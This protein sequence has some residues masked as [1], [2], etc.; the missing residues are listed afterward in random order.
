METQRV[1][2]VR[3]DAELQQAEAAVLGERSA[4]GA[5]RALGQ[6]L[7]AVADAVMRCEGDPECCADPLRNAALGRAARAAVDAG[8]EPAQLREVIA[9]AAAG[10][11]PFPL[12]PPA[13]KPPLII[14]AQT[15]AA[16]D[17]AAR[18]WRERSESRCGACT[19][20]S[21]LAGWATIATRAA[22]RRP[23]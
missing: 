10:E 1:W 9:L 5:L 13:A 12:T 18:R 16:A 19:P 4:A 14:V 22:L 23:S 11:A 15:E 2:R 3:S 8:A 21:W 6:R 7:R 17:P 20:P